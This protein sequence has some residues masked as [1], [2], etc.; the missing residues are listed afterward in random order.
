MEGKGLLNSTNLLSPNEYKKNDEIRLKYLQKL[1]CYFMKIILKGWR[2]K[3]MYF[4]KYIKYRKC[5]NHEFCFR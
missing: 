4:F 3:K 2:M 1:K 5:K